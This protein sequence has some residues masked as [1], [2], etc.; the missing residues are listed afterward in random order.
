M[1][2]RIERPVVLK[3]WAGG[4]FYFRGR[5]SISD[6]RVSLIS[7]KRPGEFLGVLRTAEEVLHPNGWGVTACPFN[8]RIIQELME[9]FRKMNSINSKISRKI[10]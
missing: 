3:W 9:R 7:L 6:G 10:K 4:F 2:Q 8:F 5:A 1:G